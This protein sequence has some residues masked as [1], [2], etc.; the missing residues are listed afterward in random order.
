MYNFR[1]EDEIKRDMLKNVKNTVDKT[2]NSIVHDALSPAAIE[3]QNAYVE[4]DY[5]AGKIDVENLEGEELEKFIYQRTGTVER[6]LATRASEKV[7][8]SGQEGSVI[9]TGDMVST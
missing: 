2:E 1:N 3:F 9:K 6:K 8:V 7:I 5:V 4:L